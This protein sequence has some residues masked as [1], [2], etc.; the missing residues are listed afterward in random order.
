MVRELLGPDVTF[1]N[2]LMHASVSG[3]GP[4]HTK[5]ASP[6]GERVS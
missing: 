3:A 4:A 1:E 5:P 2:L 6:T